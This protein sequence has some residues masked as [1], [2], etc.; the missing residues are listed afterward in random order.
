MIY[1][2]LH[3]VFMSI[4]V[5]HRKLIVLGFDAEMPRTYMTIK[6]ERTFMYKPTT[7]C[8]IKTSIAAVIV[9]F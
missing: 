8:F 7:C 4:W 5:V 9:L 1:K 2:S 6:G 3:S